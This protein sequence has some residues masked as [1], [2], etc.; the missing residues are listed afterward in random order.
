MDSFASAVVARMVDDRR[1]GV[2]GAGE[3]PAA[4]LL[5]VGDPISSVSTLPRSSLD[6]DHV[7]AVPAE[8]QQRRLAHALVHRGSARSPHRGAGRR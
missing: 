4:E 1:T 5:D 3:D 2:D 6:L 8:E 7:A